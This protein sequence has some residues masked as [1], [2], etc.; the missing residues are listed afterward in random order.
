LYKSYASQFELKGT[1]VVAEITLLPIDE[2]NVHDTGVTIKETIAD[3]IAVEQLSQGEWQGIT[4]RVNL[5][6]KLVKTNSET[7][8]LAVVTDEFDADTF[9]NN[10]DTQQHIEEDDETRSESDEENRQ[11]SVDIAPDA[12]VGPGGEGNEANVPSSVVIVC[13]VMTSSRIDWVHITQMKSCV[14]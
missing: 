2:I 13:D 5:G 6:S 14:H 7:L 10:V 1:E 4:H 8:N 11:P 3:P 12:T 9:T